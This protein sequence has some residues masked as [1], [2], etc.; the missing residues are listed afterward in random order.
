[1]TDER[2]EEALRVI[3]ESAKTGDIGDGKVF[4]S[5][6]LQAVR[7]RTGQRGDAAIEPSTD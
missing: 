1:V 3:E 7:I 4:V 6:V 5:E 2:L